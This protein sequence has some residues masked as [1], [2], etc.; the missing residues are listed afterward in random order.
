ML[1]VHCV[2][3]GASQRTPL[4]VLAR[5][6]HKGFTH[7]ISHEIGRGRGKEGSRENRRRQSREG[8]RRQ[9]EAGQTSR[10]N[11]AVSKREQATARMCGLR[12]WV[13]RREKTSQH[14]CWL[15]GKFAQVHARDSSQNARKVSQTSPFLRLELTQVCDCVLFPCTLSVVYI[16]FCVPVKNVGMCP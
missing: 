8:V 4:S 14:S 3:V 2:D 11:R 10:Q 12:C 13:G 5:N 6:L 16:V 1:G 9:K 7:E 15:F